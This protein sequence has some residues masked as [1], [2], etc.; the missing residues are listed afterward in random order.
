MASTFLSKPGTEFGPCASECVHVDCA[1]SRKQ[2]ESICPGCKGE[3]GYER[4]FIRY[5]ERL[6]HLACVVDAP[7]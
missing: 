6:W 5:S 4:H 7:L 1:A 3:I 2:A